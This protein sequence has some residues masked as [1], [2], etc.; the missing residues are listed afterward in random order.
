MLAQLGWF[1]GVC[2][3]GSARI[4][5]GYWE[6]VYLRNASSFSNMNF[7]SSFMLHRGKLK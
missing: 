1:F 3:C 7:R 2:C 5:E 4:S 6:P